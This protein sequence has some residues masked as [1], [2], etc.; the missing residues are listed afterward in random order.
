MKQFALLLFAATLLSGGCASLQGRDIAD[1]PVFG[2][3][4]YYVLFEEKPHMSDEKVYSRGYQIG[5][6][7]NQ[8]LGGGNMIAVKIRIY[9]KY[10]NLM[11]QNTIFVIDDVGRLNY[12]KAGRS[13]GPIR[14]GANVP[15]FIG[16]TGDLYWHKTKKKIG[17]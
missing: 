7:I 12:D 8:S 1:I 4:V 5:E 10:I 16:K 2:D 6:V 15:G 17:G 11:R 13:D 9:E 3:K 14:E